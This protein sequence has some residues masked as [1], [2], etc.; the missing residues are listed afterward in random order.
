MKQKEILSDIIAYPTPEAKVVQA[1]MQ[2][3]RSLGIQSVVN[4]GNEILL[5]HSV[6]GKGYCGVV[7]LAQ[8]LN[9]SREEITAALKIR[10]TDSPRDSLILEA[11]GLA[12]A[13]GFGIG[14]TLYA[15]SPNFIVMEYIQGLSLHQWL[16]TD[17]PRSLIFE[18]VE[19]I[20][21]QCYQLDQWG[22]DHGNVRCVTDHV[23]MQGN[24]P[25]LID[26]SSSSCDRKPANVTTIIPGLFWSTKLAPFL[27]HHCSPQLKERLIPLLRQYKQSP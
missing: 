9:S 10:R 26:F 19:N 25:V 23:I 11:K 14:P 7:V 12:I 6:L 13:N 21:H 24:K 20:L 15:N 1:R 22:L 5:Q 17:P 18:T 3:L 2:E 16:Q 4:F 27:R 8:W